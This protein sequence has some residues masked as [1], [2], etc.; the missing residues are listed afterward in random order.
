MTVFKYLEDRQFPSFEAA[1]DAIDEVAKQVGFSL[2]IKDK[3]PNAANPRR[4][5]LRCAKGR[6]R[7]SQANEAI[8]ESKRRKTSTQMTACPFQLAVRLGLKGTWKLEVVETP[9][10]HN[11]D[12]L[13]PEAFSRYRAQAIKERKEKII[14]MWNNSIRPFQ[15]L[16]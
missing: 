12:L 15:I 11:H 2:V 8:H 16:L 1:R 6:P 7:T 13:P 5:T 9:K 10:E 14:S 3:K 4:V